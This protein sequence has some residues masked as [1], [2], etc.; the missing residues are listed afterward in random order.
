MESQKS[1]QNLH[2][3][4]NVSDANMGK[5]PHRARLEE[6][7]E[8]GDTILPMPKEIYGDYADIDDVISFKKASKY[9]IK[10]VNLSCKV[11]KQ[12]R[13]ER[14]Y[15]SISRQLHSAA[16]PRARSRTFIDQL[17]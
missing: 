10:L 16:H 13:F 17:S 8:T 7:T 9:R 6:D 15:T 2:K 1:L 4:F 5:L 12:S 3:K 14:E 11:I